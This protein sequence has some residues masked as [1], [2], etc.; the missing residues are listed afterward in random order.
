[1]KRWVLGALCLSILS[2]A[3]PALQLIS[4]RCVTCHGPDEHARQAN[5][6][7]DTFAGATANGAIIPGDAAK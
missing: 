5:L 6:R 1:M 3:D 2:A 7:L 4:K